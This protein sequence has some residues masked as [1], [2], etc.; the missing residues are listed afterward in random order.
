MVVV[1]ALAHSL[2]VVA[3]DI[4]ALQGLILPNENGI[5]TAANPAVLSAA[6][7]HL[8]DSPNERQ[9]LAE[10][11]RSSATRYHLPDIAARYEGV[12]TKAIQFRG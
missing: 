7:R 3:T 6:I 11:A 5:L 1:E 8:L 10:G 9:R 2:P 12:L 4:P